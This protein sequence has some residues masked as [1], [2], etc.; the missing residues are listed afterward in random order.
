VLRFLHVLVVGQMSDLLVERCTCR[1]KGLHFIST[2]FCGL[3][4]KLCWLLA[5]P[6]GAIPQDELVEAMPT[7]DEMTEMAMAGFE[8]SFF[9]TLYG[10]RWNIH[11]F[12]AQVYEKYGLYDQALIYADTQKASDPKT[13]FG[14]PSP[15]RSFEAFRISGR[16]L[17]T[18]G[19]TQE[20]EEAFASACA[21]IEGFGFPLLKVL[22]VRDLKAHIL[23]KT[24]R[25]DE[26]SSLL[27]VSIEQLLGPTPDPLQIKELEAI[28]GMASSS[29]Q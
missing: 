4:L 7:V 2:E 24:G 5:S 12:A 6:V 28:L 19:R 29:W 20:A 3:N 21:S 11:L 1:T 22:A 14:L 15:S 26:G 25:S 9:H 27:K 10:N 8:W 13:H 16:C 18:L 17:A 23:D